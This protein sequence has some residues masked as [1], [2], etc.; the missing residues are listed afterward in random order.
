MSDPLFARFGREYPPGEVLF[1]EGEA[2]DVMFVIQSG[3]VRI[4]KAIGGEDKVLAVLGPGEFLGEMA[5]LNGRPRTAT[6]TV[7]EQTR[8]LV[9]EAR[10]LEQMVARNAEIALRLIKK[11]AKRLA[12]ADT[13]VE[14]LMHK[15]PKARVMLA[16][17]R[18]A[19]A[20]GEHTE[21]GIR[22][23]TTAVELAREVGVDESVAHEVIA[24]LLRL[25]LVSEE[26]S[27]LIVADVTRLQDF[28]E[29]LEMPQKFGGES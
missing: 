8:C 4:A 12:S 17:A 26:E 19:D 29:F 16:L 15:D 2:G 20:F 13:L 28:L 11:L 23:R 18:H 24:R 14:I 21:A 5:I 25:K 27:S 3:V 22:V 1:R 9:I 6:A 10:T 7:V